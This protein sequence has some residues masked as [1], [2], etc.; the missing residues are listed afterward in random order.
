M[1]KIAI[2]SFSKLLII[3]ALVLFSSS[4]QAQEKWERTYDNI[5]YKLTFVVNYM[6]IL[7]MPNGDYITAAS[8]LIQGDNESFITSTNSLGELQWTKVYPNIEIDHIILATDNSGYL[9]SFDSTGTQ[10]NR[11]GLMKTDFDGNVLWSKNTLEENNGS[12]VFSRT[13]IPTLDGNYVALVNRGS[14]YVVRFDSDGNLI[15]TQIINIDIENFVGRNLIQSADGGFYISSSKTWSR[16]STLIR[17]SV[18]LQKLWTREFQDRAILS[19]QLSPNGYDCA[20]SAISTVSGEMTSIFEKIS[21]TGATVWTTEFTGLAH[22]ITLSADNHYVTTGTYY[23]HYGSSPNRSD[24]FLRKINQDSGEIIWYRKFGCSINAEKAAAMVKTKDDGFA[25]GG[26]MFPNQLYLIKTDSLGEVPRHEINGRITEDINSSCTADP[27]E[28]GLANVFL[29]VEGEKT[30]FALTDSLGYYKFEVPL[31]DY[32]LILNPPSTYWETCQDTIPLSLSLETSST[33]DFSLQASTTCPLMEVDITAPFLRRCFTSQYVVNYCNQGTIDGENA[34]VEVLLD[35]GLTYN[36]SSIPFTNQ[37][38]N[39]FTFDLGTVAPLACNSFTIDVDVSCDTT[40]FGDIHCTEAHIYPDTTCIDAPS[41]WDGA[42]IDLNVYC[43]ND[44]I[45]LQIKNIG[46]GDMQNELPYNIIEDQVIML[47]G[48]FQLNS[49]Q[50]KFLSVPA[51]NSNYRAH[52][53]QVVNHPYLTNDLSLIFS[54]CVDNEV[55]LTYYPPEY[56]L[57]ESPS[58]ISIDCQENVGAFDPNDKTGFPT[59]YGEENYIQ[60]GTELEYLIRFQN[61]GTDTAFTVRIKDNLD[62]SLDPTTIRVGSSSHP[63]SFDLYESSILEFT[64]DNILLPDSNVNEAASHGF[65][66]FSIKQ[67]AG[68]PEGTIINNRASIYF[69][70]NPPIITNKTQHVIEY[71]MIVVSNNANPLSSKNALKVFPNPAKDFV[72]FEFEEAIKEAVTFDLYDL[73]GKRVHQQRISGKQFRFERNHLAPGM[74]F[75][76]IQSSAGLMNSGKIVIQ[77]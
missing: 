14:E 15:S 8:N 29:K 39:Q 23:D 27:N 59:G 56:P 17:L 57:N 26:F 71:E 58:Y 61:T 18:S 52:V 9:V 47:D 54:G 3:C 64:F 49:G 2:L 37:T 34:Y 73:A 11:A 69:D 66:K 42:T 35:P 22:D 67:K 70:F 65:V 13:I 72:I 33:I 60:T 4:L 38:G 10:P 32:N 24:V 20:M 40:T 41:N 31:G 6:D 43:D 28:L 30:Y 25:I 1:K 53:G 74:Y 16:E 51:N 77:Q 7:Q 76:K 5:D 46:A 75:Y 45:I 63:Y 21:A 36:T 19:L 55:P 68:L 62:P 44:S 50:S 48:Y 12:T